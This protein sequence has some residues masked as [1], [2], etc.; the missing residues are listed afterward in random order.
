MS[1]LD[2]LRSRAPMLC[3]LGFLP[4]AALA[5]EPSQPNPLH[6]IVEGYPDAVRAKIESRQRDFFRAAGHMTSAPQYVVRTLQRWK[7]GASVTVAFSGGN[8]NLYSE[9]EETVDAWTRPG[10]ANLKFV[11]RDSSGKYLAWSTSDTSYRADIR[12]SFLSGKDWGGYWSLVGN[13]SVDPDQASPGQPTLN[14]EGFESALPPDWQA[15]ALHEFGHA[16]GFEHEHQSPPGGCDFRFEDDVGYIPTK[17]EDGWYTV[18]RAGRRPGLYTYLGGKSNYWP[19]SK[20]D[21]NLRAL[22]DSYAFMIGPLDKYSIMKYFFDASM[23]ISGDDSPCYTK[24]ENEA[25]SDQDKVGARAAYPF[26]P[27]QIGVLVA[28]QQLFLNEVLSSPL[29]S[30]ALRSMARE[31]VLDLNVKE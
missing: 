19:R 29:I 8:D 20:V 14:L 16:L 17:D 26:D 21:E 7:P 11:F 31:Q 12:V 27:T 6:F 5:A 9:L 28:Q 3:G 18:D 15:V 23:F 2:F 30:E 22:P 13:A 1:V 25:L 10:V 4:Q 24:R